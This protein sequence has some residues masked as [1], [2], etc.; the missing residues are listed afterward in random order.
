MLRRSTGTAQDTTPTPPH[1]QT[2]SRKDTAGNTPRQHWTWRNHVPLHGVH[3]DVV[4]TPKWKLW[5]TTDSTNRW[6]TIWNGEG[7]GCSLDPKPCYQSIAWWD[8]PKQVAIVV[9]SPRG[10]RVR[11][12]SRNYVNVLVW[13][14][15]YQATIQRLGRWANIMP[16]QNHNL[17]L[18]SVL[19]TDCSLRKQPLSGLERAC[20]FS[21]PQ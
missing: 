7:C 5:T 10:W 18:I 4:L 16:P 12:R 11:K 15:R 3:R 14:I 8:W 6:L 2:V 13:K 19:T 9:E 20:L 21:I 17:P 1:V